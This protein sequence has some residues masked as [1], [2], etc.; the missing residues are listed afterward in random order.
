MNLE[1]DTEFWIFQFINHGF[2]NQKTLSRKE[3]NI[4]NQMSSQSLKGQGSMM[5]RLQERFQ[6]KHFQSD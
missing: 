4:G 1:K 3:L 2:K 6:N 5:T